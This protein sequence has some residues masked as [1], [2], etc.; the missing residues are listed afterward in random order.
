MI[1][2]TL[3]VEARLLLICIVYNVSKTHMYLCHYLGS[4]IAAPALSSVCHK[5]LAEAITN[6]LVWS[7]G[8]LLD[9]QKPGYFLHTVQCKL[10]SHVTQDPLRYTHMAADVS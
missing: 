4:C 6:K 3:L 8:K 9:D 1:V 7:S 10:G 5:T 2:A